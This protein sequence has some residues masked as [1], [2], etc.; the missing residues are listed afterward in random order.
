MDELR[1]VF[2]TNVIIGAALLPRSVSRQAFDRAVER[3]KLLVSAAVI[4]ELHDVL[5]RERF[6]RYASRETRLDLL[7]ALLREA[8][9][10]E[11]MGSIAVCRDPKDDMF[12]ELV[13]GGS[14]TFLVT[15]DADLLVLNP[16]RG[17]PIVSPRAFL[18]SYG[19]EENE[20]VLDRG[21]G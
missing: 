16:F 17:I 9:L 11:V 14:A 5:Q 20:Q 6:D 4:E 15:G 18:D 10:V 13:C 3:G 1:C 12:L 21:S 2:D 7:S 8:E 19:S